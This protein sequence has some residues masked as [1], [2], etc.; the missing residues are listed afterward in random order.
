MPGTSQTQ[1]LPSKH[2]TK[3]RGP[4]SLCPFVTENIAQQPLVILWNGIPSTSQ[5]GQAFLALANDMYPFLF[6][7]M[8]MLGKFSIFPSMEN[9]N[10]YSQKTG[11]KI[12]GGHYRESTN[13]RR[14]N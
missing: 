8:L 13:D 10:D 4:L 12:L 3:G 2:E 7:P 14:E 5:L 6:H 9:W 1:S 11:G